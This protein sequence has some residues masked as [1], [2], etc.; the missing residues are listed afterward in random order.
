MQALLRAHACGASQITLCFSPLPGVDHMLR[1]RP[2]PYLLLSCCALFGA[3]PVLPRRAPSH[4]VAVPLCCLHHRAAGVLAAAAVPTPSDAPTHRS[5]NCSPL[6]P[7]TCR[8][9]SLH[10]RG[11]SQPCHRQCHSG[12]A[13][14]HWQQ[15]PA[16]VCTTLASRTLKRAA[17]AA[18]WR[19]PRAG[20]AACRGA[21]RH[22]RPSGADG[23]QGRQ[24]LGCRCS[25]TETPRA[26][27]LWIS[28]LAPSH[29]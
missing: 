26:A 11:G 5:V 4:S 28:A 29:R 6:F 17:G 25:N 15:P 16:C 1:H 10:T 24:Q 14:H 27:L 23:V 20:A 12:S 13:A 9:G 22:G 2:Q 19:E 7:V 8:P 21:G 18:E 3:A